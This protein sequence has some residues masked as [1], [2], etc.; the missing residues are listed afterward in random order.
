ML[1][2][3]Y[4]HIIGASEALVRLAAKTETAAASASEPVEASAVETPAAEGFDEG[5]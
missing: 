4:P 3:L 2:Q 1:E 5:V